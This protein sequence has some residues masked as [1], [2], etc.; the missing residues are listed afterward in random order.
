MTG[1]TFPASFGGNGVMT[2]EEAFPSDS[3]AIFATF[4]RGIP[5][6]AVF[7]R[8]II[9]LRLVID[10]NIVQQEIRFLLSRRNPEARSFLQEAIDA[11]IVVAL[12]PEFLD[13]EIDKYIGK[14]SGDTGKSPDEVREQ[15]RQVRLRFHPY[16]PNQES[17][18][19]VAIDPKDVP[20]KL[21]FDE[22]GADAV[23]TRDRHFLKMGVPIISEFPGK[24]LRD[25]ARSSS[26]SVGITV[27][28]GLVLTISFVGLRGAYA[29][30]EKTLNAIGNLPGWAKLVLAAGV[31]VAIAHPQS[32]AKLADFWTRIR[33]GVSSMTPGFA[34]AVETMA[35]TFLKAHQEAISTRAELESVLPKPRRRSALQYARVI[36]VA[37]VEPLSIEEI[38]SRMNA[39][40]YTSEA[41]NFRCYLRGQIRQSRQFVEVSRGQWTLRSAISEQVDA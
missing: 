41:K 24:A 15:W 38:I 8:E 13:V 4:L 20:Y 22:L 9:Q 31:V 12:V 3:L 33:D 10:A 26:V 35:A 34:A 6:L 21:T 36:C 2:L 23:L 11:G 39:D 19:A 18:P 29:L 32:R 40:G 5:A 27:S 16:R 14:I 17:E 30:I 7:A 1:S 25:Y 37:S 28:S